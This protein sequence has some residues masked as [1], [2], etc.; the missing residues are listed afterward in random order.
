[1]LTRFLLLI[2][3]LI[4]PVQAVAQPAR[5]AFEGASVRQNTSASSASR[6]GPEPGR[7]TIVNVPLRFI[8]LN[9]YGLRDH[10]LI[11]SPDWTNTI[12][13][14]ISATYPGGITPAEAETRLMLQQLLEDRFQ[15]SL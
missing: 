3:A 14:D 9:A 7:F 1:M 12:A 6:T 11:D 13:Y 5:P 4:G 15:L 2:G 8:I 10:A